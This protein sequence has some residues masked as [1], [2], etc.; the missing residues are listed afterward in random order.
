MEAYDIPIGENRN[1]V[2]ESSFKF[3]SAKYRVCLSAVPSFSSILFLLP[4][5]AWSVSSPLPWE[6]I[7]G[8]WPACLLP[9]PWVSEG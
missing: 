7:I 6:F 9:L 1:S 5:P 2:T 4:G 8:T 3:K